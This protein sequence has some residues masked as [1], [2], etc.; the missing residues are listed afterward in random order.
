MSV[1]IYGFAASTYTRSAR[2]ALFEKG[3]EHQLPTKKCLCWSSVGHVAWSAPTHPS[4]KPLPM[5]AKPSFSS[6]NA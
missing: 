4:A 2:I 5:H 6:T 1:L 3:F